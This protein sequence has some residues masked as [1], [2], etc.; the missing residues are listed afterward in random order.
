MKLAP[1]VG[2]LFLVGSTACQTP[3]ARAQVS[4]RVSPDLSISAA[5]FPGSDAIILRWEQHWTLERDG[6][7]HRRDHKWIK[8]LNSR[9]IRR[10][11]DPR[12]DFVHGQDELIIH[13][14]QTHLP[15]G[16]ILPVPD[17]SFNY[18]GPDDVAGWPEYADWQQ[19]VI[20][21]G[22]IEN[23]AV[24]ELDYEVVTP[25]G[26]LPWI[27]AD[28]RLHD[29]YPTVDRVISVAIPEGLVLHHQVDR[30]APAD[31]G[32]HKSAA[33]GMVTHRWAIAELAASPGEP[34][35]QPWR[36]RVGRLRFTTCPAAQDW[37]ET[38]L[39]RVDQAAQ[40]N[41]VIK[42]FAESAIDE[43]ADAVQRVRKIAKKLHDSFNI[44][45]SP[46]SMR[47]LL[48]RNA[49]EVLR[50]NYGN[51]L[52][53]AALL[54]AAVRSLGMSASPLMG[55][56]ATAWDESDTL[57]PTGT[58]FAGVAIQVDLPSGSVY[59]HP[60]HGIFENPGSWGRHW[61]LDVSDAGRLK[62]TYVHARGENEPSELEIV[63]K[64]AVD[65]TGK[66][67][68]EL[69]IRATGTFFDPADLETADAQES[70]VKGLVGR[71]LS[72]FSVPGHS[73]VTLSEETFRA[74]ASVASKDALATLDE[75]HL[76]KLGDGAA[77]LP[78]IA[79]PLGRSYRKTDVELTG[80]FR[81]RIDVTI[82]LPESWHASIVPAAMAPVHKNWGAITQAVDVHDR[83]I[84]LRRN[85]SVMTETLTPGDFE[86]LRQ[87]VNDL[88]ANQSLVVVFGQAPKSG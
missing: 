57:A 12:L 38:M 73:V 2:T 20:C 56:D 24:L 14:A 5:R 25:A 79:L 21:F 75:F 65:A 69:R 15:N 46:K 64:V 61:L 41:D 88:R 43:E 35:S 60:Q 40:P 50:A 9:P 47:S 39:D 81:E 29:Y 51:P 70:F 58:A 71:V 32:F 52:E 78:D 36:Q 23:G 27:E 16:E 11:A 1:V 8:L 59:V 18:V 19:M 17:Y 68:G 22:G 37:T 74:T 26:V 53:S 87:A 6:A 31:A 55:V 44:I 63:G 82:E 54:M 67:T 85:V 84:R 62:P 33:D 28:L 86:S 49:G 34:Q 77:F 42:T 45:E 7:V 13:T 3:A 4:E 80:R 72:D 66:A 83:T 76:L 48:C 30:M 10:V